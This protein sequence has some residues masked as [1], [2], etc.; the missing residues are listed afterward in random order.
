[1]AEDD[2]G[3]LT[4]IERVHWWICGIECDTVSRLNQSQS[5]AEAADC[6]STSSGKTGSTAM[7]CMRFIARHKPPFF[8]LE[9][10]KALN[11]KGANGKTNLETLISL[12]N[13]SGYL[14]K[15]K[16]VQAQA[17]GAAQHRERYYIMGA[18]VSTSPIDQMSETFEDPDWFGDIDDMLSALKIQ[19]LPLS[20]FLLPEGDPRLVFT[21]KNEAKEHLKKKDEGKTHNWETDHLEHFQSAGLAWPPE[22]DEEFATLVK[23]LSRREAEIVWYDL[24]TL[25]DPKERPAMLRDLNFSIGWSGCREGS[26]PCI[27]SSSHIWVCGRLD[28]GVVVKRSLTGQECLSLQCF[29]HN[30]QQFGWDFSRL[31]DLA[32]NAFCLANVVAIIN[33]MIS[34]M[35]FN[36]TQDAVVQS[37]QDGAKAVPDEDVNSDL[38]DFENAIDDVDK[39]E[40]A[41]EGEFEEGGESEAS[42]EASSMMDLD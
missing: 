38:G 14:V 36:V 26:S 3:V 15:A 35:P 6:V 22:W 32:G 30:V 8:L 10:V 2:S 11:S 41:E 42:I 31:M 7:G 39:S 28:N 1:M 24:Q 21:A 12:A 33:T 40:A 29:S 34:M 27:V 25:G 4:T 18:L 16:L 5:S 19:H 23:H 17:F 9:N 20:A 37:S 13:E